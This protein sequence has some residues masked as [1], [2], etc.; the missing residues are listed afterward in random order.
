MSRKEFLRK[1]TLELRNGFS[2][3]K[4]IEVSREIKNRFLNLDIVEK[5]QRFLLYHSFGK[6]IITHDLIDDL[7][8]REKEVYIPYVIKE[9]KVLGISKLD[10]DDELVAGVFGIKEPVI[11]ED[12]PVNRM[13]IIVVPGLLF[14]KNGYRI[15]YGGGYYDRLLKTIEERIITIGLCF[16][17]FLQDSLPVEKYDISVRIVITEKRVLNIGGGED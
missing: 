7:Y 17:E 6:E 2:T 12:I 16:D 8:E 10:K 5:S 1:K 14:D 9:K 3:D 13:D 4:I 15:G 11:K